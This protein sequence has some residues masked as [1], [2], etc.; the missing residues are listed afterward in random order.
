[1]WRFRDLPPNKTAVETSTQK[2]SDVLFGP[3]LAQTKLNTDIVTDVQRKRDDISEVISY[4]D[5]GKKITKT[6]S[7]ITRVFTVRQE[8][9][10]GI[11]KI[12]FLLIWLTL[13]LLI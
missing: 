11:N 6:K 8:I 1:M 9:S 2:N 5:G 3:G 10:R 7:I 4:I 13:L 12:H